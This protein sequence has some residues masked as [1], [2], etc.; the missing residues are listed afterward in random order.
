MN[1]QFTDEQKAILKDAG[2]QGMSLQEL[3]KKLG[4]KLSDFIL[5]LKKPESEALKLMF[6]GT[7]KISNEVNA[8]LQKKIQSEVEYMQIQNQKAKREF[9]QKNEFYKVRKKLFGI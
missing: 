6:E 7:A 4:M 2:L 1:T 8:A 5:E 9:D 3:A